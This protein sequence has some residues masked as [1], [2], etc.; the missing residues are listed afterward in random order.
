ML[1]TTIYTLFAI[2]LFYFVIGFLNNFFKL[3]LSRLKQLAI[4]VILAI[5]YFILFYYVQLV[6]PPTTS[7]WHTFDKVLSFTSG[8][9]QILFLCFLWERFVK[10]GRKKVQD[11]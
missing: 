11:K 8:L 4:I 1:F 5:I 6:L 10:I 3:N 7:N 2:F 9:G